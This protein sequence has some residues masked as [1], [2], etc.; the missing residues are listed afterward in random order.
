MDVIYPISL[1]QLSVCVIY[2]WGR[3][4]RELGLVIVEA[5]NPKSLGQ[6]GNSGM[7]DVCSLT[8]WKE[9]ERQNPS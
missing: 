1:Y 8:T 4:F 9:A 7:N 6:A 5:G 3:E 2:H